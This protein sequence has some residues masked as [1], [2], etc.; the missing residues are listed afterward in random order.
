MI[1]RYRLCR[2]TT[3]FNNNVL[4]KNVYYLVCVCVYAKFYM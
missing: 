2:R 3:L 1:Y 4:F